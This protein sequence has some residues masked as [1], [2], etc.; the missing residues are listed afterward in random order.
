MS[1]GVVLWKTLNGQI[2]RSSS[3]GGK[4]SEKPSKSQRRLP[5]QLLDPNGR[6]QVS[7][8]TL[9]MWP[10]WTMVKSSLWNVG[11]SMVRFVTYR[12]LLGE[13]NA[14]LND[15]NNPAARLSQRRRHRVRRRLT[16]GRVK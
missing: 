13:F 12:T 16:S 4:N 5:F 10:S 11:V 14:A 1:K 7:G 2:I 3:D 6:Y 8:P 9:A 15:V